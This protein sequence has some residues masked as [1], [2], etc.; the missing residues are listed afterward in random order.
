MAEWGFDFARL[1]ARV[2]GVGQ[3][4]RLVARSARSPSAHRPGRRA[5]P[6]VRHPRQHQL[7]PHPRLLR[8]RP[9]ARAGRPLLGPQRPSGERALDAA[10]F[11]WKTFAA[12][13]QGDPEPAAQLRPDQRAAE[14]AARRRATSRSATRRSCARSSAGIR[15]V[16]PDRLI[17]ADGLDIGQTPV[18]GLADLGHRAEHARLPAEGGQPLH[19]HVGA[20]SE[21]FEIVAPADVAAEGRQGRRLGPG[22]AQRRAASSK[23]K[24]LEAK[25]VPIHVGEWGCFNK[26]PH[27]VALGVDD[28]LPRRCGRRP[29]GASRCGTCAAT[30][31]SSTASAPTSRYEDYK[32][33]KLDRQDAG[34]A[35]R[36]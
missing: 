32:G 33:H 29:A 12:A 22:E 25:G 23:W 36:H 14:D 35:A 28:G 24:P 9:R 2:L 20:A 18:L 7:P 8:E 11:H 19:G 31:A 13:L 6:A 1:P 34:A 4:R 10:V 5:R 27:D 26:T 16:D 17:V 15:E 30:S 21:E 3:P